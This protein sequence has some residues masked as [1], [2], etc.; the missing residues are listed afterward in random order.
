MIFSGRL[1]AIIAL[2]ACFAGCATVVLPE[3]TPLGR[4]EKVAVSALGLNLPT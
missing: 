4:P 2:A 1:P 3:G